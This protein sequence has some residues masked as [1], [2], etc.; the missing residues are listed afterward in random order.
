[1]NRTIRGAPG[2]PSREGRSGV[3]TANQSPRDCCSE[4]NSVISLLGL[5]ERTINGKQRV[6]G[7]WE[8]EAAELAV[9]HVNENKLLGPLQLKLIV[10]DT[11]VINN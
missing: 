9:Q 1:M 8:L 6:E 5:F 11:K 2:H 4:S 7:D 3:A 10:N